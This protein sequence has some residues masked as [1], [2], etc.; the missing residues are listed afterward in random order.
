[1]QLIG[2]VNELLAHHHVLV[3]ARRDP[4]SLPAEIEVI[5]ATHTERQSTLVVRTQSTIFD[6]TWTVSEIGLEDLVLAYLGQSAAAARTRT[7]P[8]TPMED[9]T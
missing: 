4:H 7:S 1:V 8:A 5:E 9:P 2:D 6:P 3:G